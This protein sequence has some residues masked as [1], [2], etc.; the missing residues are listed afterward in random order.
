[1]ESVFTLFLIIEYSHLR[2]THGF[3]IRRCNQLQMQPTANGE[4]SSRG[5]TVYY[6]PYNSQSCILTKALNKGWQINVMQTFIAISRSCYFDFCTLILAKPWSALV[7]LSFALEAA[8]VSHLKL[9]F[10]MKSICQYSFLFRFI[11]ATHYWFTSY[12]WT[13]SLFLGSF[14]KPPLS[15]HVFHNPSS[16]SQ[17][18]SLSYSF[19][20]LNVWLNL[21]SIISLKHSC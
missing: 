5:S 13:V 20:K 3:C 15:V 16:W 18:T 2:T 9:L 1:M 7:S 14:K 17:F 8:T 21:Q 6:G 19:I 11:I 4:L 12:V 10:Q